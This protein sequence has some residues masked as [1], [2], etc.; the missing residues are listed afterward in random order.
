MR[1]RSNLEEAVR[2][3]FFGDEDTIKHF[4]RIYYTAKLLYP[5]IFK[6]IKRNE[7]PFC[8]NRF[9]SKRSLKIHLRLSY[10]CSPQF[11]IVIDKVIEVFKKYV[12]PIETRRR[13]GGTY[14]YVPTPYGKMR[15]K[16]LREAI[17]FAIFDV[18][19]YYEDDYNERPGNTY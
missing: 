18:G 9:M 6:C 4:I 17:L 8:H 3:I 16:D 10:E 13:K 14:Y 5:N 1:I 12:D 2:K 7:C 11:N 15:F 19:K